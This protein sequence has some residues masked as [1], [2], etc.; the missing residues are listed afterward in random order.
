MHT[1]DE[2][3]DDMVIFPGFMSEDEVEEDEDDGDEGDDQ[4]GDQHVGEEEV[5]ATGDDTLDPTIQQPEL[6][7][8]PTANCCHHL[9]WGPLL[10]N[11][12]VIHRD[13]PLP[14]SRNRSYTRDVIER[15]G[16]SNAATPMKRKEMGPRQ[17]RQCLD[18]DN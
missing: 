9:E 8:C 12:A 13:A 1:Q 6:V 10:S 3:K 17:W 14:Q 18:S 11:E 15:K 2:T 5:L 16:K 4:H 7:S